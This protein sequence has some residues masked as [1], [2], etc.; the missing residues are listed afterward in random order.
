VFAPTFFGELVSRLFVR[1]CAVS[2]IVGAVL[3][4][5]I[6]IAM[7][8]AYVV[9]GRSVAQS[10]TLSMVDLIRAAERRQRQLLSL[11]YQ[12]KD[13]N[14]RLHLFIYNYGS[15]ASTPDKLYLAGTAYTGEPGQRMFDMTQ[16][17]TNTTVQFIGSKQLVE[18]IATPAPGQNQFDI[19]LMTKEGG[20][21]LWK[22]QD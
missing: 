12:Y 10:Q 5:M 9:A 4:A 13:G 15:E 7:S 16:A 2:E 22:F 1:R 17:G 8:V 20:I 6:T 18:L 3:I 21:F 19:I 11:T 14:G